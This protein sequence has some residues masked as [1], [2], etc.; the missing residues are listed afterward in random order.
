LS[1]RIWEDD[2]ALEEHGLC[3]N[4]PNSVLNEE[5]ANVKLRRAQILVG[6]WQL[7]TLER[8]A[9]LTG[10]IKGEPSMLW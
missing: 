7:C 5:D 1:K 3:A 10:F 2:L 8:Q 9:N 4:V 6:S